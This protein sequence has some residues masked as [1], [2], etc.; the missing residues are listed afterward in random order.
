MLKLRTLREEKNINQQKLAMELNI[1]Q[2][3]ISKY[4]LGLSE[5]DVSMLKN[6]A[7]Y[8]NVSVDYLIGFS[9][10]PIRC[11]RSDIPQEELNIIRDY[12]RMNDIQREKLKAYIQGLLQE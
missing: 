2:A 9:E 5:P 12:R 1:T 7:E 10:T 3:A 11:T 4:E 8:F 6:M